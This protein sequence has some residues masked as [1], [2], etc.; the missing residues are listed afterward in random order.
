MLPEI[1]KYL[2]KCP[3]C[4][5]SY[6]VRINIGLNSVHSAHCPHCSNINYFDNRDGSLRRNSLSS[7]SASAENIN[8]SQ[9][10]PSH[11]P[12]SYSRDYKNVNHQ[13]KSSINRESDQIKNYRSSTKKRINFKKKNL[14]LFHPGGIFDGFS[15]QSF[16]SYAVLAVALVLFGS[17]AYGLFS[18]FYTADF[19]LYS[20]GMKGVQANHVVD[21]NGEV[22]AELFAEKTG[23][24]TPEDVPEN[25][26]NILIFVEDEN[27][28]SHGGIHYPSIFRAFLK[29]LMSFGYSQG[30]STITQQLA[31]ILMKARQKT[32]FRKIREARFA[33]YLEDHFSKEDIL[34]GYMNHVYLGHGAVGMD[35]AAKFY[36]D[37]DLNQLNFTEMLILASLPSAPERYSPVRNPQRI[38]SKMNLVF[39][40]MKDDDFPS[41]S[42]SEYEN[43]KLAVFK[44]MTRSPSETVF[45]SR[46]ND[47]PWVGEYVRIRIGQI[48]G[49]EYQYGAGLVIETTIIKKCRLRLRRKLR[50]I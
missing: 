44:N 10:Y 35:T 30:G 22:I 40:R 36:F 11:S 29:N 4:R 9:V 23:S 6:T 47:A 17:F 28:Y 3:S 42:E 7:Q 14:R 25:F 34:I 16:R 21:R 27:F 15:I 31:R 50:S 26:R 41:P 32:I 45:G 48:L 18:Y 46:V 33:G 2:H 1:K 5:K 19:E 49:G 37:K 20:A 24:L 13:D 38:E 39:M 8:S 12:S 43:Q